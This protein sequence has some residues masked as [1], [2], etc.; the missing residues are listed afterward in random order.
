MWQENRR[1]GL[2][3]HQSVPGTGRSIRIAGAVAGALGDREL[4]APCAGHDLREDQARANAGNAPQVLAAFRNTALTLIR[5]LGYK[6]VEGFE[7]FAEHRLAAIE[8]VQGQRT[9]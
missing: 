1:N 8:A 9:E 2:R 6:V 4:S 3:D 7:Y 5:R